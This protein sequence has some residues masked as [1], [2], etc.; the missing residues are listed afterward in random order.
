[1]GDEQIP[2][3]KKIWNFVTAYS[4]LTT[5]WPIAVAIY[6]AAKKLAHMPS[7]WYPPQYWAS[8]GAW[9]FG[10]WAVLGTLLYMGGKAVPAV[11]RWKNPHSLT[12]TPGSGRSATLTL[13]H[14]GEPAEWSVDGRIIGMLDASPSPDSTWFHCVLVKDGRRDDSAVLSDG[15]WVDIVVATIC[16]SEWVSGHWMVIQLGRSN[17]PVSKDGVLM[18]FVVKAKPRAKEGLIKNYKITMSNGNFIEIKEALGDQLSEPT[19]G[20]ATRN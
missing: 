2:L 13:S 6:V 3:W 11:K 19:P 9:F 1:M 7:N 18:Q 10:T 20:R 16:T 8:G 5:I 4:T 14:A 17:L 12:I 15:E